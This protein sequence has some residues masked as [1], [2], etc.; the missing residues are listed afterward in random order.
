MG[1]FASPQ[2]PPPS[3]E[4]PISRYRVYAS[5]CSG[6]DPRP[7][8]NI[9][10]WVERYNPVDNAWTHVSLIPSLIEN[11]VLKGFAMAS[12]GDSIYIIGGRLC[13]KEQDH[14]LAAESDD[15]Y[16]VNAK[17]ISSVL[18]Y[19]I[20]SDLWFEC[21]PLSTP[22]YDFACTVCNNK[23]YVAGGKSTMSSS[24]GMSS[25]EVYDPLL[26]QWTLL[27]YKCV[28]VTWQGKIHVVGG[29]TERNDSDGLVS[30]VER[31]SAEVY[32]EQN[33]KWDLVAGTWQLDA[34]PNQ[35]VAIN[36]MLLS[37]GDCLI[38]WKAHVEAYDGRLNIWYIIEGSQLKFPSSPVDPSCGSD[39]K[40]PMIQRSDLTMAP[41]GTHLYLLA[42]YRMA[43]AAS[44]MQST[45]YMFDTSAR[46]G[47]WR[48]LEPIKGRERELCS[49]C[50]VVKLRNEV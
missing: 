23:I 3:P 12:I 50:C 28:G 47:G 13:R 18:Q 2:P 19:Y 20:S 7:T 40:W 14:T 46:G 34:P 26:N 45:V 39:E 38:P 48:C 35:I 8:P 24:K 6:S 30:Y 43:G 44:K 25:A 27:R 32:N 17:V 37:S 9:A 33:R 16:E 15:L 22:R 31:S 1:F 10:N 5:F 41:I 42:G 49:H 21:T 11:H 29:F 4:T 36:D